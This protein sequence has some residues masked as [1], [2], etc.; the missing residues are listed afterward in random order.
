[1]QSKIIPTDS[2]T[3][4]IR[5]VLEPKIG[6]EERAEDRVAQVY[7][8]HSGIATAAG[9]FLD[10]R[11]E[12]DQ[13]GKVRRGKGRYY[14]PDDPDEATHLKVGKNWRA[15]RP[16]ET[17]THVR[18]APEDEVVLCN[19][20]YHMVYS[21]ARHEVN[22]DDPQQTAEAFRFIQESLTEMY[23]GEQMLMVGQTDA[24]GSPEANERG[25]GG[26]FH[27]HVV[28]NA[29]L[30]E[31]M[32]VDGERFRAGQRLRGTLTDI[33]DLRRRMDERLN[34]RHHEYGLPP[35]MLA[36]VG[37]AAYERGK[38]DPASYW[39]RRKGLLSDQ[40]KVKEGVDLA[41]EHLA[42]I[43]SAD[44]VGMD[45]SDR[46]RAFDEA[47][48]TVTD[49]DVS[50]SL[51]ELKS[52][53]MKL[54]S[55]RVAGRARP[56][57]HKTLGPW[58]GDA[59]IQD[60]LEQV[61]QGTWERMP[62][63]QDL[64]HLPDREIGELSGIE[65]QEMTAALQALAER[66]RTVTPT[67][68][69]PSVSTYDRVPAALEDLWAEMAADDTPE[70]VD[71]LDRMIRSGGPGPRTSQSA[72][73]EGDDIEP[74]PR[75]R[76]QRSTEEREEQVPTAPSTDG[77]T[78]KAPEP[79]P[80]PVVTPEVAQGAPESSEGQQK[81]APRAYTAPR[82]EKPAQPAAVPENHE[83]MKIDG[84]AGVD[85]RGLELIARQSGKQPSMVDFQLRAGTDAAHG[86][87]GLSL[88]QR[89]TPKGMKHG[90]V[91]ISDRMLEQLEQAAG[92]NRVEVEGGHVLGVRA[93]ITYNDKHKL[94]LP[95]RF[96]ESRLEP[97]TPDILDQQWQAERDAREK[98]LVSRSRQVSKSR[99]NRLAHERGAQA[100][101]IPHDR[102]RGYG[103]GD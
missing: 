41:L 57:A 19:E 34:E 49:G 9:D 85:R 52:G 7:A 32:E 97:V 14:E 1:M 90:Y 68:P 75:R 29:V 95:R 26:K 25:E 17:P 89:E 44:L 8:Q 76:R 20:G 66:H 101:E 2:T 6:A 30:A 98:G 102:D 67:T 47:L 48:A 5:Y 36:S 88:N 71:E 23:P 82:P 28:V 35:Q 92:D 103:L 37:S 62:A 70:R 4:T 61:A 99:E 39:A 60:Q 50:V 27:V 69:A 13:Q 87:H 33:D 42:E 46:M 56:L 80:R 79:A 72:E 91:K 12:Y 31:G 10:L 3:A 38:S 16:G 78:L 54:R 15:A 40:D 74:A 73:A 59:R 45:L 51:R 77:E 94:W 22:P 55:F 63:H 84:F 100:P 83:H 65:R 24:E 64:T 18:V 53:E 21:F 93:D 81:P 43:R 58:Y 86:H 96:Q 11:Q